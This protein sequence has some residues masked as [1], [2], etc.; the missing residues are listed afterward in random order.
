M[1]EVNVEA[2]ERLRSLTVPSGAA[3]LAGRVLLDWSGNAAS[4]HHMKLNVIVRGGAVTAFAG[5]LDYW[6]DRYNAVPHTAMPV[7]RQDGRSVPW[8]WHDA[9]V[10]VT[11]APADRVLDTFRTRWTEAAT[12]SPATYDIGAGRRPFNPPPLPALPAAPPE[13]LSAPDPRTSV[14]VVRSWPDSKEF[15]LTGR[16]LPWS[17]LPAT[18]VHEIL[19]TLRTAIGAARR[20]IYLEDQAFDAEDTL[21]PGLVAA[22]RRG[23][24]VIA[25]LPGWV[26]PNDGTNAPTNQQLSAAVRRG[27]VSQLTA[28]YDRNLAVWR[29][30]NVTVHAK[31][32]LIDDEFLC[33]GSANAM[34][35]SLEYTLLG[36]DSE[37][38]V[39]AVS[40]GPLVADLR[41][42][43]WA[44]HLRLGTAAA[45]SEIRYSAEASASGAHPGEA[46]L[47]V[48]HP[49]N[50]LAFSARPGRTPAPPRAR[51]RR[52]RPPSRP[53]QPLPRPATAAVLA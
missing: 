7:L 35:R 42:R 5:G 20:Y 27:L 24:K 26:D 38:S 32:I 16:N 37:L 2:A 40:T 53:V 48:P 15:R 1:T 22:C 34:D 44:E 29:L 49:A 13:G 25:V 9:G 3:P 23:V 45:L 47:A 51:A 52:A 11:G 6:P 12:L 28:P 10:A 21:F 18:G 36:D 46:G 8:G 31:V 14:Q 43:L 4:S 33:V 50:P 19:R 41:V 30:S 39:A 17:T